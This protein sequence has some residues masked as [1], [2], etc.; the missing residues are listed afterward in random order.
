[1]IGKGGD[2]IAAQIK[3][4][5]AKSENDKKESY[6]MF[7]EQSPLDRAKAEIKKHLEAVVLYRV[8]VLTNVSTFGTRY[9]SMFYAITSN[10]ILY[11]DKAL[12]VEI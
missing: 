10:S 3:E 8:S 9:A 5:R 4:L 1:M 6:K 12:N 7:S 11:S 2:L